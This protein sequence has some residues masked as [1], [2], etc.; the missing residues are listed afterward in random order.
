MINWPSAIAWSSAFTIA[1]GEIPTASVSRASY[2]LDRPQ[3]CCVH[4]TLSSHYRVSENTNEVG[5]KSRPRASKRELP[6]RETQT[7]ARERLHRAADRLLQVNR[8]KKNAPLTWVCACCEWLLKP[9]TSFSSSPLQFAW[10]DKMLCGNTCGARSRRENRRNRMNRAIV[11]TACISELSISFSFLPIVERRG[12]VHSECA[13][14]F[15][16]FHLS[17]F[18]SIY[19]P[20]LVFEQV[21]A[22]GTSTSWIVYLF[23]LTW[24]E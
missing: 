12:C 1:E 15:Q 9:A 2:S 8:T 7:R 13:V 10:L 21:S 18:F 11:C 3:A 17:F 24:I 16:F 22:P 4:L 6:H 19:S 20:V 14:N 5:T 23:F